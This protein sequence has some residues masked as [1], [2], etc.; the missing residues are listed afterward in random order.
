[1]NRRTFGVSAMVIAS[2]LAG[3]DDDETGALS[4]PDASPPGWL[5]LRLTGAPGDSEALLFEVVGGPVDSVASENHRVFS[6]TQ[7]ADQLRVLLV[8]DLTNDVVA[9]VWV[10]NPSA[11]DQYEIML[12]Q[13]ASGQE[14]QQQSVSTYSLNLEIPARP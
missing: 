2:L 3:C 13:A 7:R 4:L 1:M 8:G 5:E 14:F 10:P 6:N 11:V 12:E 9:K